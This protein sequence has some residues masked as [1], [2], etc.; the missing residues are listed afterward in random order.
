MKT[1]LKIKIVS[2]A[3][4]AKIIKREERKWNFPVTIDNVRSSHPLYFGLRDHRINVVRTEC[5][6]SNI[7]YGYLRGRSYKQIENKCHEDPHWDKVRAIISKFSPSTF[8]DL[9]T[10]EGRKV[11]LDKLRAWGAVGEVSKAA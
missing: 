1:Y 3:A 6:H 2:L 9:H 5:R 4:E 10:P 11:A 7:A 8:P